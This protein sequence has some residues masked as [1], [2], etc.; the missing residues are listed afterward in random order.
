MKV[1]RLQFDSIKEGMKSIKDEYGPD[2]III[3]MKERRGSSAKGFEMTIAIEEEGFMNGHG[4]DLMRKIDEI[5]DVVKSLSDRLLAMELETNGQRLDSF[6]SGL[7]DLH[8]KMISNGFGGK[9]AYSIISDVFQE[10]GNFAN[11]ERK[12]DFFLKR[13]LSRRLPVG[14]LNGH[15]GVLLLGPSGS[16][17]TSTTKKIAKYLLER[18]EPVSIIVFDPLRK[19]RYNEYLTFSEGTGIPFYFTSTEEDLSFVMERDSRKKIIDMTGQVHMQAGVARR[20]KD[21]Q[22]LVLA[23]AWARHT[24]VREFCDQFNDTDISGLIITKLDEESR[25]GHIC[26]CVMDVAKPVFFFTTGT[27]VR[28]LVVADHEIFYTIL[29]RENLWRSEE[30]KQ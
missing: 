29:L 10:T 21:T 12:A 15:N 24:K 27:D 16:G 14:H 3:D 8:K 2:A 7:R 18:E 11:D 23:P 25:L 13:T 17:K 26:D 22:K 4:G 1:K 6:P 20:L 28:D 19:D 30:R 5:T 9:L